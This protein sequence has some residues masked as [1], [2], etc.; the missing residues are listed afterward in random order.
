VSGRPHSD[1]CIPA[2]YHLSIIQSA[3]PDLR[4]WCLLAGFELGMLHVRSMDPSTQGPKLA[5]TVHVPIGVQI[6]GL[7]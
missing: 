6:A 3:P 4:K 7:E 1:Y 5:Y 2:V